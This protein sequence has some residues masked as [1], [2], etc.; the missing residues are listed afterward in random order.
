LINIL[1]NTINCL[2]FE[3]DII[4]PSSYIFKIILYFLKIFIRKIYQKK[5][6]NNQIKVV[7]TLNENKL[8]KGYENII[9]QKQ[10]LLSTLSDDQSNNFFFFDN[11][12]FS[13]I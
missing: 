1:I 2:L 5:V 9:Q 7:T 10:K 3:G 12:S 11:K 4:I 8:K 13:K 6:E